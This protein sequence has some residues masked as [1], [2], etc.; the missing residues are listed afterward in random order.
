[1]KR[2]S[3]LNASAFTSKNLNITEVEWSTE[4]RSGKV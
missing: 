2:I 4:V 3:V 1:M